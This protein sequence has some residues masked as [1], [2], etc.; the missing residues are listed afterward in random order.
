MS[1]KK[2]LSIALSAAILFVMPLSLSAEC[3]Q[4]SY[5]AEHI[6][7]NCS[8]KA[9]TVYTCT[10]CGD[11]YQ[12]YDDEYTEPDG[13]YVLGV[14]EK[15]EAKTE[16]RVYIYNNPGLSVA[17]LRVYYNTSAVS[18]EK[19]ECGDDWTV[20]FNSTVNRDQGY[21]SVY[22][23][24]DGV[25]ANGLF[26]TMEFDTVNST[27]DSGI[28][29]VAGAKAF[30][31]FDEATGDI[32]DRD[33]EIIDL[34]GKSDLGDHLW[35]FDKITVEPDFENDGEV[36]YVCTVCGETKT[37]T[38]EHMPPWMKGDLDNN[39]VVNTRDMFALKQLIAGYEP[40]ENALW[41]RTAAD[42]NSDGS[43]NEIDVN[44]MHRMILGY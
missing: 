41:V 36:Q 5:T 43:I 34:S 8:E 21:V 28:R 33:P 6:A 31:D 35:A 39:S 26:F 11:S 32:I 25:S 18:P 29:L 40:G 15:K 38:V 13:M 2:S 14:T 24:N 44:L 1:L 7:A 37:E 3:T 23:E 16:L 30:V 12:V 10:S 4:H 22:M 42:I 19:T 9:K 27:A 20:G 17:I